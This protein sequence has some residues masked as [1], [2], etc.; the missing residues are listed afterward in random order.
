MYRGLPSYIKEHPSFVF[1]LSDGHKSVVQKITFIR[2]YIG[3]I[4]NQE[5]ENEARIECYYLISQYLFE[6]VND[7][8][9]I[10]L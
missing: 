9:K 6:I 8:D 3:Q 10:K 1:L 4:L 7:L 2:K 5:D